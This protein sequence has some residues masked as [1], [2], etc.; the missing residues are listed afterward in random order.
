MITHAYLEEIVILDAFEIFNFHK[1]AIVSG[2]SGIRLNTQ[3]YQ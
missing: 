1:F 3:Y 2:I